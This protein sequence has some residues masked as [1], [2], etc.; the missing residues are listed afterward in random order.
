MEFTTEQAKTVFDLIRTVNPYAYPLLISLI[1]P[2]YW[3]TLKKSLGISNKTSN[4]ST[5]IS[6]NL[7][8]RIFSTIASTIT[9]KGDKADKII[10]YT[11]ILAFIFGGIILKVGEYKEEVIRQKAISLKKCF[12]KR[13][14]LFMSYEELNNNFSILDFFE[15]NQNYFN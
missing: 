14:L 9:L 10:F 7:D 6:D 4:V 5:P 13:S 15:T 12:E 8:K 2:I 3:F 11:C 1:F